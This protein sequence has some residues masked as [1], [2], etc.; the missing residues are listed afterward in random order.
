MP[1]EEFHVQGHSVHV[2]EGLELG[3][4][5][6]EGPEDAGLAI[7]RVNWPALGQLVC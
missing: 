2:E 7:R 1:E 6:A 5:V 4:A 3:P